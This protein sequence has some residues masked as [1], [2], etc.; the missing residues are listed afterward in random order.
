MAFVGL[1]WQDPP[2]V[3]LIAS[4]LDPHSHIARLKSAIG[5]ADPDSQIP[6]SLVDGD[7]V[8]WGWI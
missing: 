5:L 1:G 4:D 6:R 8:G 3:E 7:D 2:Q